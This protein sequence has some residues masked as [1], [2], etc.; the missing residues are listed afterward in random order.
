MKFNECVEKVS[1]FT[2]LKRFANE[3]VI[4]YKRLSFD[5]LKKLVDRY[6]QLKKVIIKK[7]PFLK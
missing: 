1:T 3:Y 2:D 7:E 4:D 6:P 5:E